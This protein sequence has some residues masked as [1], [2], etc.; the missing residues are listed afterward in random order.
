MNCFTAWLISSG[1]IRIAVLYIKTKGNR[2]VE[3]IEE[4]SMAFN[5]KAY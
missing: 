2:K 3:P 5:V 4:H 1:I